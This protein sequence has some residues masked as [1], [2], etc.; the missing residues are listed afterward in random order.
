MTF[1]I[2]SQADQFL[3]AVQ[4]LQAH[5]GKTQSQISS[6]IRVSS[7]SDA[8]ADVNAILGL[9][10]LVARSVQSRSNI[11]RY[12]AEVDASEL[13]ISKAVE[14]M[15][16][17]SV[18]AATGGSELPNVNRPLLASQAEDLLRQMVALA[19]TNADGRFIFSGANDQQAPYVLDLQQPGGV[20]LQVT[21]SPARQVE[22][23]A[24]VTLPQ[25]LTADSIFDTTGPSGS[26]QSNIFAALNH[27]RLA[28]AQDNVVEV[29]AAA[30]KLSAGA[31]HLN[32]KLAYYGSLQNRLEDAASLAIRF[33]LNWQQ[34]LSELRDTDIAAAAVDLT[35][36]RTQLDG[37][38]GAQAQRPAVSL[39]DYLK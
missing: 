25:P 35:Q 17:A 18:L 30:G 20:Q 37:A 36:T 19:G 8:P 26:S 15:E 13:A 3:L 23:A 34:S 10:N 28:L 24:G 31:A 11:T 12:R 22:D 6:G 38:Y 7:A 9:Q 14:L 29:R 4:R 1:R 2:N 21:I 5:A 39:F 33:E 16:R 27:L 32:E